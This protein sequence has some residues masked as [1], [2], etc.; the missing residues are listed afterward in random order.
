MLEE[1]PGHEIK[2]NEKHNKIVK[3]RNQLESFKKVADPEKERY[4]IKAYYIINAWS[5]HKQI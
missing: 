5:A 3:A 2:G 4:D 1:T